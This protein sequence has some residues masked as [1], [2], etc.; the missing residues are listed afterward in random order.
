MQAF[1]TYSLKV[2]CEQQ[3]L[4]IKVRMLPGIEVTFSCNTVTWR[5][6]C[7]KSHMHRQRVR[8][9]EES[10]QGNVIKGSQE[11]RHHTSHFTIIFQQKPLQV[12]QA[13]PIHVATNLKLRIG[14][15]QLNLTQLT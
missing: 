2:C 3:H 4:E 13:H 7:N 10:Q 6:S 5:K 1:H 15:I 9:V 8:G 11:Q 12:R 14:W